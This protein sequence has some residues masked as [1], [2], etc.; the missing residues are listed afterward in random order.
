MICAIGIA[1]IVHDTKR[2]KRQA[3][4]AAAAA[5]LSPPAPGIPATIVRCAAAPILGAASERRGQW[6]EQVAQRP[7]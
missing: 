1:H 3:V 2:R 7:G 6:V 5:A 4:S